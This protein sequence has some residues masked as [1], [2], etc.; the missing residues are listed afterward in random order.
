[1]GWGALGF[2]VPSAQIET[3]LVMRTGPVGRAGEASRSSSDR[4]TLTSH[5]ELVVPVTSSAVCWSVV[6][7][8]LKR[9]FVCVRRKTQRML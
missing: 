7:L 9:R 8:A 5:W 4:P 3:D 2:G 1:M 6:V